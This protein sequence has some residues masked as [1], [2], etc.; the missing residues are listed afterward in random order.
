VKT[1]AAMCRVLEQRR[2]AF[3]RDLP[4]RQIGAAACAVL[5]YLVER[6]RAVTDRV[7]ADALHTRS[8]IENRMGE[9]VEMLRVI[10]VTLTRMADLMNEGQDVI[11]ERRHPIYW[12]DRPVAAASSISEASANLGCGSS[13]RRR[14][15]CAARWPV[16][17]PS[18]DEQGWSGR[19][20]SRRDPR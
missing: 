7:P 2:R 11:D 13:S 20:E 14:R 1:L 10:S 8:S 16:V 15:H 9:D 4:D 6:A 12:H 17:R 18:P 19:D 3:Q 5:D